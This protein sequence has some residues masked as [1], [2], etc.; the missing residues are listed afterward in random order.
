[1]ITARYDQES[2]TV[3]IEFSGNV[4]TSQAEPFYQEI[5]KT[6]P[7]HG[8][9]FKVLTDFTSL[10]GMDLEVR[11]SVKRVMDFLNEQGVTKI[12]RVIPNP[13]KDIGFGIMSIFH[14]SKDVVILNVQSREEAEEHLR[15]DEEDL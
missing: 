7:K 1:M 9:G 15:N 10:Q 6:V 13:E 5:Q 2:N 14:Y 4:N 8:K 12:L 11:N 3:I